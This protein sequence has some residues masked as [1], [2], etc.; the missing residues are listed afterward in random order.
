MVRP[1]KRRRISIPGENQFS[2]EYV[3]EE[4]QTAT[5]V[6]YEPP[7]VV[8]KIHKVNFDVGNITPI[9]KLTILVG[10]IKSPTGAQRV[11][12]RI[13]ALEEEGAEILVAPAI[14]AAVI[15]GAAQIA[16]GIITRPK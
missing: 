15:I 5:R 2:D 16:H 14:I 6:A 11:D 7:A 4:F 3:L 8:A 10:E 12:V 1:R 9:Q 13:P